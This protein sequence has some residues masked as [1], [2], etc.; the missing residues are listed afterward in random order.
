[1]KFFLL[2]SIC[3]FI[4][5]TST[6]QL[7]KQKDDLG[8]AYQ[9]AVRD[10]KNGRFAETM[11]KL[12]PL[13]SA[14]Q[15][16]IFSEYAHYYY[17]L[18]AYEARKYKESRQM[19]LQLLSRYP[20]WS[21]KYE[22]YYLLGANDLAQGNWQAAQTNFDRIKDTSFQKDVQS[23]KQNYLKSVPDYSELLRLYQK[24]P[25]D[26]VLAKEVVVAVDQNSR[27][28]KA[29]Q[30]LAK[31]LMEEYKIEMLKSS[32]KPKGKPSTSN[33]IWDKEYFDVSVLMPFRLNEFNPNQ[34]RSNQFA[35]D[36][37]LGLLQAKR[38]LAQ[39]GITVFLNAYDVNAEPAPMKRIL[40]N[41]AFR[42]SNMVIGPLYPST[43]S[44]AA[45]FV[46]K[47]PMLMLNPLS[48]DATLLD[49][50]KNLYLAHP[51]IQTQVQEGATLMKRLAKGNKVAIYYGHSSK[52]SAM[53]FAYREV[54]SKEGM[55]V[56]DMQRLSSDREAM[57]SMIPSFASQSPDHIALFGTSPS[58]GKPLLATLENR[59]LESLP[60]LGTASSFN[61]RQVS[62]TKAARQLYL[63]ESDFIDKDKEL[64]RQFQRDYW[65][66]NSTF[67]SVYA[68]QGYDHLL[69]FGRMMG[70]YKDQYARG[71]TLKRY[72]SDLNDYLLGGFDY[73]SS[74]EN[75]I[76]FLL[77]Y[78]GYKWNHI[79]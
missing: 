72:D 20:N 13:T 17:S 46:G 49:A 32:E 25:K 78:N 68:Y 76:P 10:Y 29:D 27:A 59:S 53:A 7:F 60:V 21:R 30:A 1:M 57:E 44:I 65:E 28:S 52:D 36:Y 70:K 4:N 24:Y 22:V 56:I 74:N 71:L 9:E 67:P 39:E 47:E 48:T 55:Q 5:L 62:S 33:K 69:F 75:R 61:I 79:R 12:A 42:I 11:Q 58:F 51:S 23:L 26:P 35:Y 14:N 64:I 43:F 15:P 34:K 41:E 54:A 18:A 19:L 63:L 16:T 37:Y 2:G 50:A 40:R 73:R 66:A 45:E 6:A 38:K 31:K 8:R 77:K 3:L